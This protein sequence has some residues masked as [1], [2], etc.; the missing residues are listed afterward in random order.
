MVELA[1]HNGLVVGSSPAGPTNVPIGQSLAPSGSDQREA[2][3]LIS[4]RSPPASRPGRGPAAAQNRGRA[5]ASL[6][7]RRSR[8]TGSSSLLRRAMQVAAGRVTVDRTA[9]SSAL[10]TSTSTSRSPSRQRFDARRRGSA[11]AGARPVRDRARS[12]QLAPADVTI[13]RR[14]PLASARPA[15]S[16]ASGGRMSARSVTR[17]LRPRLRRCSR[18]AKSRSSIAASSIRAW[19]TIS[20]ARCR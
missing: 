14:T 18:A 8:T 9:A 19:A 3:R 10:R 7:R 6:H 20:A 5:G 16:S 13:R 12:A 2:R 4:P 1:A 11:A 17:P 15:N